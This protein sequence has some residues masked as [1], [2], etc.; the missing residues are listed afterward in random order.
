[1]RIFRGLGPM[2]FLAVLA[3]LVFVLSDIAAAAAASS[4]PKGDGGKVRLLYSAFGTNSYIP[5]IVKKFKLDSK[6]GFELVTVSAA[7][8]QARVTAIQSGSA[9]MGTS[10]WIEIARLRKAGVNM[11]G[12]AP[13]LRWGADFVVVP[14]ESSLRT[15]GDLKGKRFGVYSK[16]SL[17]WVIERLVAQKF[18]GVDLERDATVHEAAVPLLRG[19]LEQGQLD[20]SEIW[21]SVTPAM[22][23]TGKFRVL[24]K[25][26]DLV[27]QFGLPDTPFL[28]YAVEAKYLASHPHNIRAFV[29]AYQEAVQ[30]LRDNDEV[31]IERGR[32]MKMTDE[33]AALF[34]TEARTDIWKS[35]EAKTESDIKKVFDV[36][37]EA[38]GPEIVGVDSLP[39]RFMTLE[40]Q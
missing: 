24:A 5:F 19:L 18:Y 29:A 9:E 30:T 34:R 28:L 13:F 16:T 22:V 7:T 8:P 4:P 20:A 23:A 10:D 32:E 14:A 12:V 1:M 6:Y 3:T 37:L 15:L 33:V 27:A 25:D 38:A 35:F 36:L 17:N 11:V 31:W 40:Y 2:G 39:D 21:N 26:S